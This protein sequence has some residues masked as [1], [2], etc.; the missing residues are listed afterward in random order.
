MTRGVLLYAFNN[1]TI[2]YKKIAEWSS[3]RIEKYLGLPTTIISDLTLAKSGGRRIMHPTVDKQYSTWYNAARH[4]AWELSPYDQT[5]ILD[6]DYIVSSDQLLKL[7]DS[8]QY[9]AC[10]QT[11]V[12]ATGRNQFSAHEKFGELQF[13]Q[14]WATVC[15]FT[16]DPR[17][18]KIFDIIKMIL[19]NYSHY[20][21]L[22]KF[23]KQPFR[24][25]YAFSIALSILSGHR[26][27]N[28]YNIPWPLLNV[29]TDVTFNVNEDRINL[30]Y[31]KQQRSQYLSIL[32]QDL[33]VLNKLCLG[34]LV[35]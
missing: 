30:N 23:A 34:E 31:L 20:A 13:P 18:R 22:Y 27:T 17:T 2:N 3:K 7:F 4:T 9:F 19:E 16:R 8:S 26:I 1:E 24:N 10:H 35:A 15:Y 14:T 21:N 28:D 6:V 33:H 29:S 25:D 11:V 5:I 12:D 32:G